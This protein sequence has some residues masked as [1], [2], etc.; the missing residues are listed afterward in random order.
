MF[1]I[2]ISLHFS[3]FIINWKKFNFINI[4]NNI[5][6]PGVSGSASKHESFKPHHSSFSTPHLPSS[7]S[8]ITSQPLQQGYNGY[9]KHSDTTPS[10][11]AGITIFNYKII[12]IDIYIKFYLKFKLIIKFR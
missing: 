2:K 4:Y 5:P 7:V 9:E 6:S 10:H 3:I 12:I 11:F 8:S 1:S